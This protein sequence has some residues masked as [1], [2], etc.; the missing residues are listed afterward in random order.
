MIHPCP[1][2]ENHPLPCSSNTPT[3]KTKTKSNTILFIF[4]S[5]LVALPQL[6]LYILKG[7][8][9]LRFNVKMTKIFI[10]H[11]I[12]RFEEDICPFA[13]EDK[14]KNRVFAQTCEN[15]WMCNPLVCK[16]D[17]PVRGH[18]SPW[19]SSIQMHFSLTYKYKY[20]MY[21]VCSLVKDMSETSILCKATN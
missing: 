20:N 12:K 19:V 11:Q 15:A 10:G 8:S 13:W 9:I 21:L 16:V 3:Q 5:T 2:N 14:F 6:V 18:F 17:I 7:F 4:W 1:I